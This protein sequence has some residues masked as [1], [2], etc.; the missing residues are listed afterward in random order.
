MTTNSTV[1]PTT[2]ALAMIRD[3]SITLD[4]LARYFCE[5]EAFA[6]G[7]VDIVTGDQD[8]RLMFDAECPATKLEQEAYSRG[9]FMAELLLDAER[10]GQ[11][12]A[13][14]YANAAAEGARLTAAQDV[15]DPADIP[16]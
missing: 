4:Q 3:E 2:T 5:S 10:F 9:A 6:A 15:T 1:N 8:W 12:W 7:L 16:F 14:C 13:E 11:Q